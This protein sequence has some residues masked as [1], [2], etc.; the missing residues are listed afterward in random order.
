MACRYDFPWSGLGQLT[1]D[2]TC[3]ADHMG[4]YCWINLPIREAF[5][6]YNEVLQKLS[7]QFPAS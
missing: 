2:C 4:L 1:S 3:G 6:L 5:D 7:C